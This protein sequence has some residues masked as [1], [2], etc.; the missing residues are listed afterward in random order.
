MKKLFLLCGLFGMQ[1]CYA[2]NVTAVSAADANDKL[3][4]AS[5]GDTVFMQN[6]IY[7]NAEIK[8][9]NNRV[10]FMAQTPGKVFFEGNSTLVINGSQNMVQ[11][12]VWRNGGRDLQKK[13]II[14][15]AKGSSYCT[16]SDCVLDDYNNAD[17]ST[18]NKWVSLNGAYHVFTRNLLKDKRNLGATLTVWLE[19]GTEAHHTISHNYFLGRHNGPNA[20]NGLESIRIGDSR[21]HAVNAHCVVAFNRFEACD[22]EIEII[23][24]KSCYNSY[25]FNTF[26]NNDGGLTLRHGEHALCLGNYF[27]GGTKAGAYGIRFIGT[28]HVAVGNLFY[29]LNGA[30]SNSF[31]APVTIVNGIVNSEPSGYCR[32]QHAVLENNVFINCSTPCIRAGAFSKRDNM[33][34]APDTLIIRNNILFDDAGKVGNVYEELTTVLHPQF[35]GNKVFGKYLQPNVKGFNAAQLQRS[36][37]VVTNNKSKTLPAY[38]DYSQ[39]NAGASWV[40]LQLKAEL[41]SASVAP[42]PI[43]SVGPF[44]YK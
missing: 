5:A 28:G 8:L 35:E 14:T 2:N 37:L 26:V 43:A 22:G 13:S 38:I 40:T 16:V 24:N 12:F 30:S 4:K 15:F 18:D 21:T 34:E 31:K 27:D 33:I 39:Y 29:N 32:V 10:V 41:A 7:D 44:W 19:P 36:G 1:Y 3:A 11:G 20:G 25:L 17:L 23:S 42:L 9:A 6:G